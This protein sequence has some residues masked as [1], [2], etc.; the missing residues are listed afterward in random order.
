MRAIILLISLIVIT[1]WNTVGQAAI[2]EGTPR[3]NEPY[4]TGNYPNTPFLFAVPTSG[5][6]PIV[7]T[8][9]GLPKGL[10]ID[11]STGIITG[12]VKEK[13]DYK[14]KITAKNRLGNSTKTLT[15]SIGDMLALTP[16]MGWNSWNTFTNRLSDAL[17][18]QT[19]DSMVST[20]MRD[21][22]YQYINIDD[23]WQLVERD[24]EGNIQINK[25]KFPYGIKAVADY[26]HSRG[27]K[28]GIYSDAA[29]LTCGGVAGSYG[30]EEQDAKAF[31]DWGIDLLK[32]DYCGAPVEKDSA[33]L[34]YAAM[35]KALGKT[36]RSIVYSVCEWGRR[37][38]WTWAASLGGHYWR[39]T[40]DIRNA[41]NL[42]R[43]DAG[44]N[45]VM[46]ILDLNAPLA[47]YAGPGR[48]NDPDMLIVGI[49]TNEWAE[50]NMEGI[51]G[52]N[53][54]EFKTHMSL[55]CLMAAPLLCG[56]DI[57]NMNKAT[58]EI[59][60]NQEIIAINQDQLGKQ[61]K[62]VRDD[63]DTEIFIKPMADKSWV[64]GLL[65]RSEN[66]T[67]IS[68]SWKELGLSGKWK[69]RDIWIHKD[70]GE[71]ADNY[72]AEV[73]SHG[74]TVIRIRK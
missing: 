28:L 72:T 52:C 20:G 4:I 67:K 63:G 45:S 56:N 3:I 43:Y 41:W 19:A 2:F 70:I 16:P 61:A 26:V 40:W 10:V 17:V 69:V 9:R 53:D 13:G 7:W 62:R 37:E 60:L 35:S 27:L 66:D 44:H 23:F 50:V 74:C 58:R 12:N 73:P 42:S 5:E 71:F 57:R 33:V 68:V 14:V 36:D 29:D 49:Y 54:E 65:N 1:S 32:Y 25:E 31:A 18:R 24:D 22:G 8:A 48:W 11:P 6:R 38:P 59:L 39:T 47:D 30:F 46:Q 55:W 21:I 51:E 34:R 15:I 64:I